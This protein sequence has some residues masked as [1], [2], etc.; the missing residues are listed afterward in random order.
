MF[1]KSIKISILKPLILILKYYISALYNLSEM[2][3][4]STTYLILLDG[5]CE[6]AV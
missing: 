2:L 4:Y 5:E 1:K 6:N 3:F